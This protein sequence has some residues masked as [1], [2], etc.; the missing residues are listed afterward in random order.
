MNSS[1]PA[2]PKEDL[3]RQ[4]FGERSLSARHC[5]FRYLIFTNLNATFSPANRLQKV[6]QLPQDH[7][8]LQSQH[9]SLNTSTSGSQPRCQ[10]VPCCLCKSTGALFSR[11]KNYSAHLQSMQHKRSLIVLTHTQ[12]HISHPY[13]HAEI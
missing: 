3:R 8:A 4:M 10:P 6:K 1:K 12:T 2:Q 9:L 5:A 7:T 13:T 11:P